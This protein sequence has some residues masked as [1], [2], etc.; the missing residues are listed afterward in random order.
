MPFFLREPI[1]V[2]DEPE[3]PVPPEAPT[4]PELDYQGNQA[5][6][7]LIVVHE[8]EHDF[9]SVA[10]RAFLEKVLRAV[11]LGIDHVVLV[12]GNQRALSH[13][14]L[15]AVLSYRVGW[16]ANAKPGWGLLEKDL[17]LYTVSQDKGDQQ[18]LRTDSLSAI[19]GS[20]AKKAQL[21]QCLQQLFSSSD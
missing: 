15:S 17:P 3:V 8:P 4:T 16:I 7:M 19:A 20:V 11:S 14:E 9:L 12:N 5:S 18:W 1:Y 13:D 2:V 10:D 21:W 6:E